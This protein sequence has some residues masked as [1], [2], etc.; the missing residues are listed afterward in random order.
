MPLLIKKSLYGKNEEI[1]AAIDECVSNNN[2]LYFNNPDELYNEYY[3]N[4]NKDQICIKDLKTYNEIYNTVDSLFTFFMDIDIKKEEYEDD[5]CNQESINIHETLSTILENFVKYF[6]KYNE[7]TII[8]QENNN[9]ELSSI[10]VKKCKDVILKNIYITKNKNFDKYSF[11][12]YFPKIIVNEEC[13]SII[14]DIVKSFK[15]ID[16]NNFVKYID[17]HVY[18]KNLSLRLLYCKKNKEDEFYHYPIKC[19][20][21]NKKLEIIDEEQELTIDTFKNYLFTFNKFNTNYFLVNQFITESESNLN[22]ILSIK[23]LNLQELYNSNPYLHFLSLKSL[24]LMIF[25]SSQQTEFDYKNNLKNIEFFNKSEN[26]T[27]IKS[28]I[29]LEFDYSKYKCMFCNAKSHK[30]IHV[31][32]IGNFGVNIIKEGRSNKCK[33]KSIPYKKLSEYQICEFIYKKNLV[34]RIY[35]NELII[36]ND[37]KGWINIKEGRQ[38]DFSD[39]KN[40]L[41]SNKNYFNSENIKTIFKIS[42]LKLKE[43]FKSLTKNDH[44]PVNTYYPYLFKFL[45]GIY[46]IKNDKFIKIKDSNDLYVINSVN[47]NYIDEKDYTETQKNDTIFIENVI[48]EIMPEKINNKINENREIFEINISTCILMAYKDV[49]TVFQGETSAGKTTIKNLILSSLGRD[50]YIELPISSYTSTID[51]NKPNPW[52]GSIENKRVSFASESGFVDK[53][54]SQTIK[55]LT[56]PKIICRNMYSSETGQINVLSQFIDTNHTLHFDNHDPAA[57]RRLAIIKFN[58]YFKKKDNENLILSLGDNSL[59]KNNFEQKNNLSEDILNNKYS[60]I[61]FN[62]LKKWVKKYHLEKIQLKNTS[63]LSDFCKLNKAVLNTAFIGY[64]FDIKY[65]K[66]NIKHEYKLIKFHTS[67]LKEIETIV[68]GI[69]YFKKN[70]NNFINNKKINID[71]NVIISKLRVERKSKDFIPLVLFKDIKEDK[72]EEAV[73]NYNKIIKKKHSSLLS[74]EEDITLHYYLENK[75]NFKNFSKEENSDMDD[76]DDFNQLFQ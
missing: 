64:S 34:K 45:N 36:F 51:P 9:K 72:L 46:D 74:N 8:V 67:L 41:I 42:E 31:I 24:F 26:V 43:H 55:L 15:D 52:L 38:N 22:I 59:I 68:C 1:K 54:N 7:K 56:E 2:I 47:Y 35:N 71:L 21:K 75:N 66:D 20:Y 13:I 65:L 18:K 48:N 61:F 11:H 63:I 53:I 40:L 6:L 30:N 25:T 12:I 3:K 39:L 23:E 76:D 37:K 5:V 19:L 49:I 28:K 58:S 50:N 69:S 10:D 17:E 32:H 29:I 70:Y 4:I 57:Y 27:N 73:N 62:I 14:K 33:I 44:I 60:I 16:D